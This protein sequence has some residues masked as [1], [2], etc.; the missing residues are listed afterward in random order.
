MTKTVIDTKEILDV[1]EAAKK[2]HIGIATLYRWMKEDIIIPFRWSRRT[3]IPV[4]EVERI[5]KKQSQKAK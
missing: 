3:Y 4:S 1:N 5:L 2:L